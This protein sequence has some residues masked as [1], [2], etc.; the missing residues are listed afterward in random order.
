MVV[1]VP[2]CYEWF[3]EWRDEPQGKRSSGYEALK[4]SFVEASLSAVLK[5]F[6]QLEGKVGRPRDGAISLL[7]LGQGNK[8]PRYLSSGEAGNPRRPSLPQER[9]GKMSIA[10][11]LTP[12]LWLPFLPLRWTV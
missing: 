2:A 9:R 12:T 7:P 3:E 6:P 8:T 1:L 11:G 5:L 10:Q 4:A